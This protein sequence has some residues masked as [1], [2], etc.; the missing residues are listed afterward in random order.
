M[1]WFDDKK[2]EKKEHDSKKDNNRLAVPETYTITGPKI[3]DV[4]VVKIYPGG[5]VQIKN[6]GL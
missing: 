5:H 3:G 2:D 6:G 4:K 1:N